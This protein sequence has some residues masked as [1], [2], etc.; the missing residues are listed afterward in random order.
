VFTL[1]SVVLEYVTERL[2]ETAAEEIERGE[3]VLLVAQPLIQ[4]QAKD[5]VRQ[6]QE[7]LIGEPIL[8]PLRAGGR[9]EQRLLGL[10]EG[11]R[12]RAPAE[13]GYGPGNV[14]NLLR[15]WHARGA[16]AVASL[17]GHSGLIASVAL[18]GD[19]DVLV[20][21]GTDGTVR[22][23]SLAGLLDRR[24]TTLGMREETTTRLPL[25]ILQGHARGVPAVALSA[26]G[27]RVAIG[28]SDGLVRLWERGAEQPFAILAG[29]VGEVRG[30]AFSRDGR[31]V[32]SGSFDG[33]V[34]IW[35]TRTRQC[36]RSLQPARPY[37]RL[38]IT[39][40]TGITEAQRVALLALGAV[41]QVK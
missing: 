5:Y 39:R 37:E 12:S 13:H 34:K 9:T 33:T 6:T 3:P 7:R 27:Q 17:E 28:S 30:V 1:Q 11:W 18:S 10:L 15:L 26:D 38:D 25:A 16:R 20:S 8:Q 29:H 24:D 31:L 19:G 36:L 2:I 35:D 32:V 41:E 22:L 40:L 21:G 14:V 23:W 4:A